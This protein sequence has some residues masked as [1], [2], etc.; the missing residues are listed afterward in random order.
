MIQLH[1][2]Y[3]LFKTVNGEA[4]PCS[5]EVLA[6]ELVGAS[7]TTLDPE[8][9]RHAAAAVLHYY[10]HDLGRSFVSVADFSMMLERVLAG[11]GV[12]LSSSE[13]GDAKRIAVCDLRKLAFDSGKGFELAFFPHLREEMQKKLTGSPRVLRFQGLRGCVK[14]ILGAKRWTNRCQELNDQIVDF[15]RHCL[16]T[17]GPPPSCGLDIR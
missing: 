11:L 15:L 10:K 8:L 3:L 13:A 9:I 1:Q 12:N 6:I 17:S 16:V 2:D 7:A 14:Q 5:A 4:I